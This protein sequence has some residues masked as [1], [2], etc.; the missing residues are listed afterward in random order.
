MAGIK[1]FYNDV[2]DLN[3]VHEGGCCSGVHLVGD[4]R[5]DGLLLYT[6]VAFV[7]GL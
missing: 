2:Y 6:Q 5:L 4:R 3:A 7:L 1:R